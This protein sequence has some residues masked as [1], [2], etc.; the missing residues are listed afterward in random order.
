MSQIDESLWLNPIREK[1][2]QLVF[3]PFAGC[4]DIVTAELGETVVLHGALALA[5]D[6]TS[7][8]RR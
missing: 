2:A 6:V 8:S 3:R 5:A 1:V 4:C 7:S